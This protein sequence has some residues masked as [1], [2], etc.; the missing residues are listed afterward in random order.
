MEKDINKVKIIDKNNKK[1]FSFLSDVLSELIEDWYTIEIPE[2][3]SLNKLDNKYVKKEGNK[4]I[5][6]AWEL[7]EDSYKKIDKD[8]SLVMT[9]V[10]TK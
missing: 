7:T 6:L 2:L 1:D 4:C 3:L 5:L 8:N 10:I 9:L